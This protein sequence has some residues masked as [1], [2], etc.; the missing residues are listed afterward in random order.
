M[1]LRP[2]ASLLAL[3]VVASPVSANLRLVKQ[4]Q[5]SS[6]D[7]MMWKDVYANHGVKCGAGGELQPI[8]ST[9]GLKGLKLYMA[10]RISSGDFCNRTFERISDNFCVNNDWIYNPSQWCYVSS[11][12]STAMPVE[13]SKTVSVKTCGEGDKKL[14]DY[15]FDELYALSQPE[16]QDLLFGLIGQYAWKTWTADKWQAVE[17]EIMNGT[18][19]SDLK[20]MVASNKPVFITSDSAMPPFYIV[21]G[22]RV[23]EIHWPSKSESGEAWENG[24]MGSVHTKVCIKGCE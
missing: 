9:T 14:M 5:G 22:S 13:G 15:S 21:K 19:R 3:V 4:H 2:I 18:T 16:N 24:R 6:C 20:E 7:C 17:S 1:A 23:E 12:C 10:K 11:A 8:E